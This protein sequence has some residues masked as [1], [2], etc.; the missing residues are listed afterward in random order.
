MI[1]GRTVVND[2]FWCA[3]VHIHLHIAIHLI[4]SHRVHP[5]GGIKP[6]FL[7]LNDQVKHFTSPRRNSDVSYSNSYCSPIVT[8]YTRR[9]VHHHEYTTPLPILCP[10]L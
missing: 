3:N 4:P 10:K 6:S 7:R 2:R 5:I 9:V 1:C 8:V